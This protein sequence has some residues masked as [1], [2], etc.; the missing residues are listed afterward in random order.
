MISVEELKKE[1]SAAKRDLRKKH[2]VTSK[3]ILAVN[4][5][6]D[7][8]YITIQIIYKFGD[9]TSPHYYNVVL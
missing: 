7:V 8:D 3:D 6:P 1:I 2:H 9:S 4:L 5:W